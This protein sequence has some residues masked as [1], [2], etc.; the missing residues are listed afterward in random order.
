MP[1]LKNIIVGPPLREEIVD[2]LLTRMFVLK[3]LSTVY[4]QQE[5]TICW[6]LLV[7]GTHKSR[8]PCPLGHEGGALMPLKT[9]QGG[10]PLNED[11]FINDH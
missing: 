9:S 1:C 7:I 2:D 8:L 4:C 5:R 10:V 3:R 6:P 11:T